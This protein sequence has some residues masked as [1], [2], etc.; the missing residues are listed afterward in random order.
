MKNEL[1]VEQRK[2]SSAEEWKPK[3]REGNL[4]VSYSKPEIKEHHLRDGS[5]AP[6]GTTYRSVTVYLREEDTAMDVSAW[7]R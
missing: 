2:N 5:K 6:H 7:N 4:D 3:M 1:H